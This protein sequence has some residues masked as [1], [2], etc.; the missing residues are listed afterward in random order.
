[1]LIGYLSALLFASVGGFLNRMVY[2]PVCVVNTSIAAVVAAA[3]TMV[4]WAIVAPTTP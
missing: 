3:T 1:M 2:D 4:L